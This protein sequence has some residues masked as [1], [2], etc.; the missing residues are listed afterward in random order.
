MIPIYGCSTKCIFYV[1][2]SNYLLGEAVYSY[3]L[4]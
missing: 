2:V 4:A 3:A 1:S